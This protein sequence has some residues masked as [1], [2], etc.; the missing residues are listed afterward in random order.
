MMRVIV[1]APR[2]PLGLRCPAPGSLR[3]HVGAALTSRARTALAAPLLLLAACAPSLGEPAWL[4]TGPQI[5]ALVGD[6]PEVSPGGSTTYRALAVS[7]SGPLELSAATWAPCTSPLPLTETGTVA[8]ACLGALP[9]AGQGAAAQ[10][11]TSSDACAIFGP[12]P[13]STGARPRDPDASGGYYQP[14]RLDGRAAGAALAFAMERVLCPLAQASFAVASQYRATYAV[15]TNPRISSLAFID[16]N[17]NS[18]SETQISKNESAFLSLSWTADSNESFPALDEASLTLVEQQ[19]TMRVSWF[20]TGG[21]LAASQSAAAGGATSA[22][23]GWSAPAQSG[24]VYLWAVLR[25][26]RGGQAWSQLLAQVS[27]R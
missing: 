10:L 7:P 12:L 20:A 23:V 13:P 26:S 21:T 16:L 22:R 11:A 15:N 18:I 25:D 4:V 8:Q 17:G 6:A 14:M 9:P 27:D 5:L 1:G 2:P 3:A 19:E 24:T